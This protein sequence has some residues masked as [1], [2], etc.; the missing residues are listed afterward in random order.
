MT[1]AFRE[2]HSEVTSIIE[3]F[4]D[5]GRC[6]WTLLGGIETYKKAVADA[7]K[8]KE[9]S[10]VFMLKK[11]SETVPGQTRDW[12]VYDVKTF[13]KSSIVSVDAEGSRMGACGR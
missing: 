13:L 9:P 10:R 11:R 8:H 3:A 1:P 2:S 12:R 4:L 7:K 6:K 5:G